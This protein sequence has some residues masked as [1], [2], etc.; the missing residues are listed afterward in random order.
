MQ[1]RQFI[2]GFGS[3]A[4][5][6]VVARAQQAAVPV[7][8][9]LSSASNAPGPERTPKGFR[10]G[11]NEA[12]YFVGR[13]VTI[14]LFLANGRYDRLPA[15]ADEMVRRQVRLIVAAGGVASARAAKAATAK[16]P[17]LFIAG[18]DP[19]ELG[20]VPR[21][22]RPGGNATGLSIYTTELLAKRLQLL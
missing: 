13:N 20:L 16:I 15:L 8:G 19:V 2:A 10:A 6:P 5:W 1:R 22:N 14:E 3:A 7:I 12:G 21:I 11:L 9:F 18:F 17:I 4:V